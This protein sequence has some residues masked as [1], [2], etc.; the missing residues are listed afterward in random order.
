MSRKE[1]SIILVPSTSHAM[2]AEKVLLKAG[3]ACK[4]IPVP[5]QIGSDCGVCLRIF[6]ADKND[7]LNILKKADLEITGF[8][9]L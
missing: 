8:T 1:Y 2:R 9:D 5:R 3:I 7:T 6:R 4:L